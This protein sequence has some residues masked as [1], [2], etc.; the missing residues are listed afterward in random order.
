VFTLCRHLYSI[1]VADETIIGEELAM[2]MIIFIPPMASL[3]REHGLILSTQCICLEVAPSVRLILES[4][5]P[6][7]HEDCLNRQDEEVSVGKHTVVL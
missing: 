1:E 2:R 3:G 6:V 7:A 5:I 4:I